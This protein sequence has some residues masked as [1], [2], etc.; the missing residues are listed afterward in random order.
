M[1]LIC[2]AG[3]TLHAWKAKYG[4]SQGRS[5]VGKQVRLV[6]SIDCTRSSRTKRAAEGHDLDGCCLSANAR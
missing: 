6:C 1:A 4:D 5:L 3:L 2:I